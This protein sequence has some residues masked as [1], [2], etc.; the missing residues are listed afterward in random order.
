MGAEAPTDGEV[1]LQTKTSKDVSAGVSDVRGSGDLLEGL[2][3]REIDIASIGEGGALREQFLALHAEWIG[4]GLVRWLS[5]LSARGTRPVLVIGAFEGAPRAEQDA[6]LGAVIGVW[7][8]ARCDR[9]DD[10]LEQ[11]AGRSVTD[12]PADGVWHLIAVTTVPRVHERG[13]GL[14]RMLLGRVLAALEPYG[15]RTVCTLSPALGLPVLAAWWPGALGDAILHA[16]RSDG[17]PLLPVMRLHLG[18]GA[19]LE[20]VL[21]QSRR[22]DTASGGVN[23][24]FC[25]ATSPEQRAAQRERWLRWIAARVEGLER[26]GVD[27]MG[28]GV[29]R[30]TAAPDA[31]V[32]DGAEAGKVATLNG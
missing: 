26:V 12:R 19:R 2:D 18:G 31:L 14:G 22:D 16:A 11:D 21:P 3:L 32:F 4:R 6:L 24:R 23:L 13:L 10:L 1:R 7:H 17:R 8:H 5:L 28:D 20:R 9:F 25:Y 30:A 15:H 29:F 27:P